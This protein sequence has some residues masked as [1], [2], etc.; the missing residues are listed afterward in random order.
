M[1]LHNLVFDYKNSEYNF[2]IYIERNNNKFIYVA[3]DDIFLKI[4]IAN[5]IKFLEKIPKEKILNKLKIFKKVKIND[6]N[7]SYKIND[8]FLEFIEKNFVSN[9]SRKKIETAEYLT[10]P[11]NFRIVN[12]TIQNLE[13]L[14]KM[15]KQKNLNFNFQNVF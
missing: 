1:F 5:E 13:K 15:E 4:Q 14:Q 2:E 6:N 12:E 3:K 11:L 9:F 7:I 8:L 10:D